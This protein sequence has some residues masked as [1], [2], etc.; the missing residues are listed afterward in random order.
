MLQAAGVVALAACAVVA[1]AD[2]FGVH[3]AD[4][5]GGFDLDGGLDAPM[6]VQPDY[7]LG[8]AIEF[9]VNTAACDGGITV[10]GA[11]A[12]VWVSATGTDTDD[13]GTQETPCATIGHALGVA[14]STTKYVYLD[15]ATFRENV[16]LGATQSGMT[17]QGG[18]QRDAGW[19]PSCDDSLSTIWP[20]DDGGPAAVDIQGAPDVTL[21]LMTVRSKTNGDPGTGESVYAVRV[22]NSDPVA[23]ENVTLIAQHGGDGKWGTGG[24]QAVGCTSGT[25]GTGGNGSTG[26]S[27]GPGTF[28]PNGFTPD[29]AGSGGPGALGTS[30]PGSSGNQVS[31]IVSCTP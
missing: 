2:V 9:D 20:L 5:D 24:S 12:A 3:N 21:R 10:V 18:F 13:C 28:G 26:I 15:Q 25:S 1:C 14:G 11:D 17:I 23:L 8:D 6:D 29:T 30:T 4:V 31:C 27:G 16:S 19:T 7:V 22:E